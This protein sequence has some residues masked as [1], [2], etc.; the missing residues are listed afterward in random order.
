MRCADEIAAIAR[1][2][3]SSPDLILVAEPTRNLD[4]ATGQTVLQALLDFRRAT[5]TTLILVTHDT[6]IA[7]VADGVLAS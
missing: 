2:M 5:R 7:G 6:E 3:A 1:A 4:S